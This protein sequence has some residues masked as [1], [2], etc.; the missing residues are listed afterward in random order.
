M[1]A[2][3]IPPVD[4]HVCVR[5]GGAMCVPPIDD[6]KNTNK[7]ERRVRGRHQQGSATTLLRA[8]EVSSRSST[9]NRGRVHSNERPSGALCLLRRAVR[10]S[11]AGPECVLSSGAAWSRGLVLRLPRAWHFV[12][13]SVLSSLSHPISTIH[14]LF[15]PPS[16]WITRARASSHGADA[17]DRESRSSASVNACPFS[18][19]PSPP[20]PSS[21]VACSSF[22]H[23]SRRVRGAHSA[24]ASWCSAA[25]SPL[26]SP[27][28]WQRQGPCRV[29]AAPWR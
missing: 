2:T 5:V 3:Q 1:T 19:P 13:L 28:P 12:P 17:A 24:A 9:R 29:S 8:L 23:A 7:T 15:S 16:L 20:P 22:L 10:D 14:R 18:S 27:H 11:G 25:H 21:A 6:K 26:L 4:A